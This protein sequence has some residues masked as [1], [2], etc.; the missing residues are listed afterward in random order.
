M[1]RPHH[2]RTNRCYVTIY[3]VKGLRLP[4]RISARITQGRHFYVSSSG[5]G[6]GGWQNRDGDARETYNRPARP[7][8]QTERQID[9]MDGCDTRNDIPE[10][11]AVV[12]QV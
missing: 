3:H 5:G 10:A 6:E 1:L 11:E 8:A 4:R 7:S 2:G 9:R 12:Q